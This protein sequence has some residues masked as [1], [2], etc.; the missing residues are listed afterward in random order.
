M[1]RCV[2][3]YI[4]IWGLDFSLLS[5]VFSSESHV[6]FIESVFLVFLTVKKRTGHCGCDRAPTNADVEWS[7]LQTRVALCD[8]HFA[9]H[10][11]A[12]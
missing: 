9:A 7:R 10:G 8:R 2:A 1:W 6:S 3:H 4:H 5:T 12:L 11:G